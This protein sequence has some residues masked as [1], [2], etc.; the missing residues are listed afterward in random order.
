MLN[1]LFK[2]FLVAAVFQFKTQDYYNQKNNPSW[3]DEPSKI[4]KDCTV[5]PD[6]ILVMEW[7]QDWKKTPLK[8]NGKEQSVCSIE[9]AC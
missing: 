3:M 8:R 2:T 7:E 4:T 9:A 1:Q 5:Q 6:L